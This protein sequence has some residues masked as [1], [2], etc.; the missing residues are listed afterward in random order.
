MKTTKTSVFILVA[1]V[2]LFH[3]CQKKQKPSTITSTAS[4]IQDGFIWTENGGPPIT[5]D[6]A[7]WTTGTFGT[8]IKAYQDRG[9]TFFDIGLG[10]NIDTTVGVKTV[11]PPMSGHTHLN[12]NIRYVV[13]SFD[14][15][16]ISTPQTLTITAFK[17]S[18]MS[19]SFTF[20][21]GGPPTV[22]S[23]TFTHLPKK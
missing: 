20:P 11:Y 21:M 13:R 19:G 10:P 6:S 23:C 15:R 2:C 9:S 12:D 3:S 18:Q 16:T 7:Y 4:P 8:S 22:I 17:N 1:F 5:A 14:I